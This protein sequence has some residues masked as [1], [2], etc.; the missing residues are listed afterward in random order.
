MIYEL[1]IYYRYSIGQGPGC[2]ACTRVEKHCPK[3]QPTVGPFVILYRGD[4]GPTLDARLGPVLAS[5]GPGLSQPWALCHLVLGR[6]WASL[7]TVL[8]CQSWPSLE[9]SYH[10]Y[11]G[12]VLGAR[13][14]PELASIGASLG[15]SWPLCNFLYEVPTDFFSYWYWLGR[16]SNVVHFILAFVR[17][18]A[19]IMFLFVLV[20][21][22]FNRNL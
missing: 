16:S 7:G 5:I 18:L 13:L 4:F 11:V 14:G 12:P 15:Q 3:L 22:R 21:R 9:R 1:W 6:L 2:Q 20:P 8:A 17:V 19:E 10:L